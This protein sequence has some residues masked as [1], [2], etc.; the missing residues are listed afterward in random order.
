MFFLQSGSLHKPESGKCIDDPHECPDE[1]IRRIVHPIVHTRESHEQYNHDPK[2]DKSPLE[3]TH[4]HHEKRR[5][6]HMTRG[7]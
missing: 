7:E 1:D 5:E 2:N 4:D 3:I 6:C